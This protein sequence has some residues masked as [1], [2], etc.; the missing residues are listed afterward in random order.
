MTEQRYEEFKRIMKEYNLYGDQGSIY[1]E[2]IDKFLNE[3]KNIVKLLNEYIEF[4]KTCPFNINE[5][6]IDQT[7]KCYLIKSISLKPV[8][9]VLQYTHIDTIDAKGK[10]K[11]FRI[12]EVK[13]FNKQIQ[14]IVD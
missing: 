13:R 10:S 2:R 4:D 14:E 12:D 11:T 6:V 3:H 8:E 9:G 5:P 7:G 1:V